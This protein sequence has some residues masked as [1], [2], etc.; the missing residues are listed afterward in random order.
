MQRH[1]GDIVARLLPTAGVASERAGNSAY[2][3]AIHCPWPRPA[4]STPGS[5]P[6]TSRFP[7]TIFAE[8]A[9]K[10]LVRVPEMQSRDM[11]T[12]LAGEVGDLAQ[13]TYS[14]SHGLIELGTRHPQGV[15]AAHADRPRRPLAQ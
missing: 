6:T 1:L 9:V 10:L 4:T 3:T 11:A 14:T 5:T 7:T 13:I 8:P 12:V 15:R 2:D